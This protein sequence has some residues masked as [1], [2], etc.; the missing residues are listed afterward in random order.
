MKAEWRKVGIELP[1]GWQEAVAD[2]A[3]Q[4]GVARR[5]MWIAAIDSFLALS[6]EERDKRVRAFEIAGRRDV[7]LLTSA[8]CGAA[9]EPAREYVVKLADEIVGA[10]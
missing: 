7:G 2:A 4:A 3:E 8:G 5:Y 9:W 10:Q 1:P 6:P